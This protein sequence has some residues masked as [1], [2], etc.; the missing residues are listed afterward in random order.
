MAIIQE[1]FDIPDDIAV[2]LATGLYRRIGGV[3]RYAVGENK[4]QI[5]KHLKPIALP[6]DEQAAMSIAQKALRFGKNHKE[7]MIGTAAVAGVAAVAG[8]IAVGVNGY[9]K[10][11][12]QKAFKKYIDAIKTGN[13][14]IKTIEDMESALSNIKSVNMK[15]SELSVLVGHI[16]D[17]TVILAKNNSV[18]INIDETDSPIID[19]KQYI[20]MQKKILKTA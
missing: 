2:G 9:K 18:E 19:L 5:V 14:D 13:L 6:K 16:R 11:K 3:V 1:A 12:F 10:S 17:Y 8:G 15:A 4:G 7:L 20:Q